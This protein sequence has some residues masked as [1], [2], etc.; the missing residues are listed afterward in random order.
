MFHNIEKNSS[1]LLNIVLQKEFHNVRFEN[2]AE[3]VSEVRA[4]IIPSILT[5]ERYFNTSCLRQLEN[6][7]QF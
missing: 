5:E 7:R 3:Y 6:G 2:N 4:T 1:K